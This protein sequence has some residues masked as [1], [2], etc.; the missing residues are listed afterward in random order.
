MDHFFNVIFSHIAPIIDYIG[1]KILPI[2]GT[3]IF[4]V[5]GYYFVTLNRRMTKFNSASDSFYQA[6][7]NTIN[8][9]SDQNITDGLYEHLVDNFNI[10]KTAVINFR[11]H[12]GWF[13]RKGFDKAWNNYRYDIN[14]TYPPPDT[15]LEIPHLVQYH[16]EFTWGEIEKTK[17][18]VLN[19]IHKLTLYSKPK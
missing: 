8:L 2:A 4:A 11:R 19:R 7:G 15:E 5:I 13:K 10:H 3:L 17:K 6:F 18:D 16:E 1:S 9:F 12:L 14:K